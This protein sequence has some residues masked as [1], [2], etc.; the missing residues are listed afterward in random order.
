MWIAALSIRDP[1]LEGPGSGDWNL[2]GEKVLG[3]TVHVIRTHI[4]R[5]TMEKAAVV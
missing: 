4:L 3:S 5:T 1:D 2:L